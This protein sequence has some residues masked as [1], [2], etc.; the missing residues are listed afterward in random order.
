[1]TFVPLRGK[2][3]VLSLHKDFRLADMLFSISG[4]FFHFSLSLFFL[5]IVLPANYLIQ[6]GVHHTSADISSFVCHALVPPY[7]PSSKNKIPQTGAD[8]DLS[9]HTAQQREWTSG[10]CIRISTL[11]LCDPQSCRPSHI[12]IKPQTWFNHSEAVRR[13]NGLAF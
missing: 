12:W 8:W 11:H 4:F 13:G 10:R 7:Q 3:L 5:L 6:S 9:I 1:M 2:C